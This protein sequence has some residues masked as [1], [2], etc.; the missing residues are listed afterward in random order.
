ME[1]IKTTILLRPATPEDIKTISHYKTL[2][3]GE[4]VAVMKARIGQVYKLKSIKTGLF[5]NQF[6]I[7]TENTSN[8]DLALWL[9]NKMLYIPVEGITKTK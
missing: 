3:G 8:N 5:D 7:I 4:K 2:P 9:K 6:Y 1:T